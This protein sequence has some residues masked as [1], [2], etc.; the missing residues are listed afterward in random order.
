M[1]QLSQYGICPEWDAPS[2][3]LAVS[4]TRN[5]VGFSNPPFDKLNLGLH[6]GDNKQT[7][8]NNRQLLPFQNMGWLEQTHSTTVI[9]L[10]S[11]MLES[12]PEMG[13]QADASFTFEPDVTCVVMTADCLPILLCDRNATW[14]AA[15]HAGW[16]GLANGV[17]ESTLESIEKQ[18]GFALNKSEISAWI[19]PAIGQKSYTVGADVY[20]H[21]Q[22]Y[23]FALEVG[24]TSKMRLG[25]SLVAQCKLAQLGV[26]DILG[27]E[28]CTFSEPQHFFSYRRDGQTGRMASLISIQ[29]N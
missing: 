5:N 9:E 10:T 22:D 19:G 8:L 18:S 13:F 12:P 29:S 27:G 14:V 21:F 7:V 4:T 1:K 24:E 2:S 17:I 11:S 26:S 15:I 16:K 6:V 20:H 28:H 25:L 3:I 23:P